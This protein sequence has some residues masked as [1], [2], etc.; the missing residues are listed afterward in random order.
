MINVTDLYSYMGMA[1][2]LT[3]VGAATIF[4]ASTASGTSEH[5]VPHSRQPKCY[6]TLALRNT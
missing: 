5:R 6:K 1:I 4:V 3:Y 2:L